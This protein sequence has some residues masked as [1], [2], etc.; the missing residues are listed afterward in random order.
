MVNDSTQKAYCPKGKTGSVSRTPLDEDTEQER[1]N[2]GSGGQT[3]R[4]P[5]SGRDRDN[6]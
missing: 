1:R 4:G 6:A 3:P 2:P 5:V